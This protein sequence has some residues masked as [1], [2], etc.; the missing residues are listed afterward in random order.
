MSSIT[1]RGLYFFY[2]WEDA[3]IVKEAA[4]TWYVK[5]LLSTI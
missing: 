3:D 4:K 5:S 2:F 1:V